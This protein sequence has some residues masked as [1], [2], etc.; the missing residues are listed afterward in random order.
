MVRDSCAA[1]ISLLKRFD[2]AQTF[3]FVLLLLSTV[4]SG[5]IALTGTNVSLFL[6]IN[7]QC[8]DHFSDAVLAITTMF[9]EGWWQIALLAMF[10]VFAPRVNAAVIYGAPLGFLLTQGPKMLLRVPRPGSTLV[11]AH[12]HLIGAPTAANSCPS[13]HALITA[14]VA[15]AI[16]LGCPPIRRRTTCVALVS[17]AACVISLSRIAIGAHWPIDVLIGTAFGIIAGWTGFYLTERYPRWQCPRAASMMQAIFLLSCVGLMCCRIPYPEALI[18]R[19]AVAFI[20][21]FSASAAIVRDAVA[22]RRIR[23]TSEQAL[24]NDL[25]T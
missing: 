3:V 25:V 13:G 15:T 10:L 14:M 17:A 7:Q 9:G 23:Q 20:G 19:D 11:N 2:S 22:A 21:I 18:V 1:L 16:I 8:A 6:W 12:V 4:L 24:V 5:A